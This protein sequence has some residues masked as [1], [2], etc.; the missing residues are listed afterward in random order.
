MLVITAG[1][2]LTM[3]QRDSRESLGDFVVRAWET[4]AARLGAAGGDVERA[5]NAPEA[6]DP[7]DAR[8]A[9]DARGARGARDAMDA[10]PATITAGARRRVY[11]R[12][13]CSYPLLRD[14]DKPGDA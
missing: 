3:V 13:G 14:R 6:E 4:H 12:R 5:S 1:G 9:R 7:R 11:A 10:S 2:L 8:D